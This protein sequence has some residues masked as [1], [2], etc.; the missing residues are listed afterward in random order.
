[1]FYP[2]Q[3]SGYADPAPGIR[4]KTLVYGEKTLFAEFQLTA[5]HVLPRHAHPEEQTGYLVSGC[6]RLSVGEEVRMMRPGDAWCIAGNVE[7]G[8]E[9]V[10]NSVAIEVFSPVRQAYLPQ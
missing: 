5:G 9:I 8:A 2:H 4:M 6:I 10:E 1:M 7:H 3:D